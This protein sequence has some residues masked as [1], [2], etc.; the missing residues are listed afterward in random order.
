MAN[1]VC[2]SHLN[3][4]DEWEMWTLIIECI[5]HTRKHIHSQR[6]IICFYIWFTN[7]DEARY[8]LPFAFPFIAEIHAKR[9]CLGFY[10]QIWSNGGVQCSMFIVLAELPRL[11]KSYLANIYACSSTPP[12]L[13]V[14][15]QFVRNVHT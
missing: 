2:S 6:H 11:L 15:V 5:E 8:R 3:M 1:C 12:P 13:P 7:V 10:S 14:T 4:D 9:Q